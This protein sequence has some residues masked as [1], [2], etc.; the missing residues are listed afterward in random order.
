MDSS[1][2]VLIKV[3]F[4]SLFFFRVTPCFL[5]AA[6]IVGGGSRDLFLTPSPPPGVSSD[7]RGDLV[8]LSLPN[9]GL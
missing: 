9:R 1:D 7:N 4:D 3:F 5:G 2:T 8:T 6:V